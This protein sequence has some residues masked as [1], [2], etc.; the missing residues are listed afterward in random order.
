MLFLPI[1]CWT[2]STS[3]TKPIQQTIITIY[4]I[5]VFM[6]KHLN[7]QI[8][9]CSN[10]MENLELP[11]TKLETFSVRFPRLLECKVWAT[12]SISYVY[13]F[14]LPDFSCRAL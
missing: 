1:V 13:D 2:R 7:L 10:K 9:N 6:H 5:H 3:T 14:K 4:F 8:T 12:Q 11:T